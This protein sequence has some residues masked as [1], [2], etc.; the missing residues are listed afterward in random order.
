MGAMSIM[1][2]AGGGAVAR[3]SRMP[4]PSI[5][6]SSTPPKAALLAAERMP[7]GQHTR[8]L[9]PCNNPS[10]NPTK[11]GTPEHTQAAVSPRHAGMH[12]LD[13]M[14][15]RNTES[16]P[17][18]LVCPTQQYPYNACHAPCM[19]CPRH[20]TASKVREYQGGDGP[21]LVKAGAP[22][23]RLRK[24]PVRAP[25]AM[26]FQ[27]SSL[28]RM[29]TSVQSKVENRPPHTAKLPP[30]RGAS[31]RMACAFASPQSTHRAQGAMLHT[32]NCCQQKVDIAHNVSPR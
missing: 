5:I 25:A 29:A 16:L 15:L 21:L 32:R 7:A 20:D 13:V 6:A 1:G 30:I 26:E 24:P 3:V 18:S 31:R 8:P 19:P 27:G 22:V 14:A 28:C 23:R 2:G 9:T 4:S 17:I 11:L 12:S 10:P